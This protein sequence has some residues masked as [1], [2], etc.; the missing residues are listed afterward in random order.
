MKVFW[1]F[2]DNSNNEIIQL[3]RKKVQK[4]IYKE[5]PEYNGFI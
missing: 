3:I 1:F 2:A 5:L 4:Q